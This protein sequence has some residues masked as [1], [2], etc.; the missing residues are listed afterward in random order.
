MQM[1][2]CITSFVP[3]SVR[4]RSKHLRVIAKLPCAVSDDSDPP[5]PVKSHRRQV[6]L[7]T[8]GVASLAL[9]SCSGKA[10]AEPEITQKIYFDMTLDG[11]PVG[12]I[13]LGMYGN[14]V[15]KTAANFVALS[16]GEKGFGYKG[17]SIHR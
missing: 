11:E 16:T 4:H 3:T 10:L 9:L 6:L 5:R 14:D 15:P 17:C 1:H 12:R 8:A 2:R 13:V 7:K